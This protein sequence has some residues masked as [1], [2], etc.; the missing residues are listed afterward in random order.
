M[1]DKFDELDTDNN[2]ILDVSELR[3]TLI[4]FCDMKDFMA[5]SVISSFDENKDGRISRK[6]FN[7]LWLEMAKT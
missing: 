6:E 4:D 5:E 2:G 3:D 1:A 7:N